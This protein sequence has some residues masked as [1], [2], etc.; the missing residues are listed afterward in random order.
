MGRKKYRNIRIDQILTYRLPAAGIMSILH[1]ISGASLFLILPFLIYLFGESVKTPQ[2]F[3]K[4]IEMVK[5]PI[6]FFL[7]MGVSWAYIHHFFAGIRHLMCDL[8][9]GLGKSETNKWGIIV[10]ISALITSGLVIYW[11]ITKLF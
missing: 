9:I 4:A 6:I 11:A 10:I 1:R 3:D 5:S 8:H 2:S 7:L